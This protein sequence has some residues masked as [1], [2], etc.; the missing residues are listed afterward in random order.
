MKKLNVFFATTLLVA[1]SFVS[2]NKVDNGNNTDDNG[3]TG[4]NEVKVTQIVSKMTY[5][6]VDTVKLSYD[7]QG[8]VIKETYNSDNGNG[9]ITETRTYTYTYGNGMITASW[10]DTYDNGLGGIPPTDNGQDIATLD[11][12]DK[13]SRIIHH[14]KTPYDDTG[15]NTGI[16]TDKY[17]TTYLAYNSGGYIQEFSDSHGSGT[18][19][20]SGGNINSVEN[21]NY[22][23]YSTTAITYTDK[24]YNGNLYLEY[25]TDVISS[26]GEITAGSIN[27]FGILGFFGNRCANL[28]KQCQGTGGSYNGKTTYDYTFND[29]GTV[30]TITEKNYYYLD[31]AV[32][33][34]IWTYTLSY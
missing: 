5:G 17:D 20:W 1:L 15:L 2:C 3:S 8:R 11:A 31:S 30:N 12:A 10:T 13:V 32:P 24:T 33:D 19:I 6:E 9:Q 34:E 4:G 7:S 27:A 16:L 22:G 26:A 23:G 21:N 25:I 18:F 14:Y 29:D 28:P